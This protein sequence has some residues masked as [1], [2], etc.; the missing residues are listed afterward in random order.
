MGMPPEEDVLEDVL[1]EEEKGD[2]SERDRGRD[3]ERNRGNRLVAEEEDGI[4][5]LA[6]DDGMLAPPNSCS[7]CGCSS[8]SCWWDS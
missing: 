3:S 6:E 7:G 8:G 1:D 4:A 5:K 2:E